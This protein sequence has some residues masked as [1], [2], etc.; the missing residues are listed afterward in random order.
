MDT[1]VTESGTSLVCGK[2]F[3]WARGTAT[4][5][6]KTVETFTWDNETQYAGVARIGRTGTKVHPVWLT[7]DERRSNPRFTR[8]LLKSFR[9][10]CGGTVNGAAFHKAQIFL[11]DQQCVNCGNTT[12]NQ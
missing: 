10:T 7:I 3:A 6:G 2:S 1:T 12:I 5:N 9:C 11:G 8:F 4:L